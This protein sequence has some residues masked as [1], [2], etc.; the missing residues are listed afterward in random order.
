MI[1]LLPHPLLPLTVSKL[2]YATTQRKTEEERQLADWSGEGRGK[3][4]N[5]TTAKK[6]K[7]VVLYKL[8]NTLWRTLSIKNCR[9]THQHILFYYFTLITYGREGRAS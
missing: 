9:Q 6:R 4:L 1:W 8:F 3:K 5:H 2:D 7:S